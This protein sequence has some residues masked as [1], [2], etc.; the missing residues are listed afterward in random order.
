V[1]AWQNRKSDGNIRKNGSWERTKQWLLVGQVELNFP[2]VLMSVCLDSCCNRVTSNSLECNRCKKIEEK[3]TGIAFF[4]K[5]K[6]L[7]LQAALGHD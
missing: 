3:L 1:D 6:S 2:D 4:F 5:K 7:E